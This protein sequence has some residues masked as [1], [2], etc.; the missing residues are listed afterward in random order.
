MSYKRSILITISLSRGAR[1]RL[2]PRSSADALRQPRL[3]VRRCWFILR[4]TAKRVRLRAR[5]SSNVRPHKSTPM[6]S[7]RFESIA[8]TWLA[9]GRPNS[10]LLSGYDLIAIRCWSYSDGAKNQGMSEALTSFIKASESVQRR[11]WIDPYMD[12]RETCR[13]CGESYRFENISLCTECS[14]KYCYK[15]VAG[16]ARATNGNPACSCGGEVVG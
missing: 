15:C 5:L 1:R 6:S 16:C 4:R 7:H 10:R 8:Q 2:T 13:T 9:E 14:R 3:A 12:D 11:D